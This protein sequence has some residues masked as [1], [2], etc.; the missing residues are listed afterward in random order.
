MKNSFKTTTLI[1]AV[2]MGLYTC[3]SIVRNIPASWDLYYHFFYGHPFLHDIY[4]AAWI[5]LL[6]GVLIATLISMFLFKPTTQVMP[7][8]RFRIATYVLSAISV[9]AELG[10]SLPIPVYVSGVPY[11]FVPVPWRIFLLVFATIWLWRLSC[12]E[13][14]GYLSKALRISM[15][16]GAC[17]LCIPIVLQFV[18]ATFYLFVGK[19]LFLRSWAISSWLYIVPTILLCWYSIELFKK[20]TVKDK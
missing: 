11:M 5:Y 1:T 12:Q 7:S 2:G 16:I 9:M 6:S 18:S 13:S 4:Y 10:G 20:S 8:K 3:H 17:M 15:I 19:L 14:I